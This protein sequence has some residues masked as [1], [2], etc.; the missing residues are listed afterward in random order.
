MGK[1]ILIANLTESPLTEILKKTMTIR[2]K[3]R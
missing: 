2:L 1:K 3:D